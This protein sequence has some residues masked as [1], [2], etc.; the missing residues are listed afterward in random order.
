MKS[1]KI[2][3]FVLTITL[4]LGAG[5]STKNYG[6]APPCLPDEICPR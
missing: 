1:F 3:M 6:G 2:L 5:I 4:T